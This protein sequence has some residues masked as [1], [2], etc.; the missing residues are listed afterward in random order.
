M[1]N[2]GGNVDHQMKLKDNSGGG[3][4]HKCCDIFRLVR[5]LVEQ[6]NC[7]KGGVVLNLTTCTT[8]NTIKI[9]A[10]LLYSAMLYPTR[11]FCFLFSIA[12]IQSAV[13][14]CG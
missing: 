2:E 1:N 6:Q 12:E 11:S 5:I 10:Q 13:A 9:L 4:D 7:E 3:V 8:L 14:G